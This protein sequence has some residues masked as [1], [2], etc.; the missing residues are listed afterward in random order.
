MI[1]V[2]DVLQVFRRR[3]GD[4]ETPYTYEDNLLIGYIQDGISQVEMDWSRGIGV[5]ITIIDDT[6]VPPTTTIEF[7]TNYELQNIDAQL[8]AIK[9]H[10]IITL[11]TKSKAD[12]DNF[13]MVKGRLTLDNTNQADDHAE[14][15]R[16]LDAE[17]KR[18]LFLIKNGGLANKGVRVE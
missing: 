8:F 12:R 13:R 10:Y 1:T 6:V 14:T 4:T 18:T 2:N 11:T 7:D 9:A 5:T 17:Y 15:L 16:L 3:I